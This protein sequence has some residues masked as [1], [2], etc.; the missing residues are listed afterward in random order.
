MDCVP[1]K[2]PLFAVV[3]T[4]DKPKLPTETR[5]NKTSSTT[6]M[7]YNQTTTEAAIDDVPGLVTEKVD[8][9]SR[10]SEPPPQGQT[11][12]ANPDIKETGAATDTDNE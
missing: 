4:E 1:N 10:T 9:T 3:P 11:A 2:I 7:A 8:E 12:P 5:H 6:E